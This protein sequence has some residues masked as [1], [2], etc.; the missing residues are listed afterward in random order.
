MNKCRLYFFVVFFFLSYSITCYA[1]NLSQISS[2]EGLSNS[3]IL[4][5]YQDRDGFMWFGSCDGLNMYDGRTIQIYKPTDSKN[6]LSGNLIEQIIGNSD[7]TLWVHTN[8]GL[9]KIDKNKNNIESHSQFDKAYFLCQ[10]LKGEIFVIKK[11]NEI[12]YYDKSTNTFRSIAIKGLIF[13]KILNITVDKNDILWI[14]TK[15]KE[16]KK[17]AIKRERGIELIAVGSF[18]HQNT[19]INCFIDGNSVFFID[20]KKTLY[21]YNLIHKKKQHITNLKKEIELRGEIS[22][23]IKY[24]GDYFVGFK[25]NGLVCLRKAMGSRENYTIEDIG[26]H[27]GVFCLLKDRYQDI[28]WIGTDGKGVFIYSESAYSVKSFRLKD[29]THKVNKPIRALF[30]DKENTLWIGTKGDGILK[31]KN[32]SKLNNIEPDQV[33]HISSSNSSLKDNSV[34]S[35]A[36]SSRNIIWIGS[37]DGIGYYSYKERKIKPLISATD[38]KYIHSICESNDSTLWIASVGMGIFKASIYGDRDNPYLKNIQNIKVNNGAFSSNFFFHIYKENDSIIWFG[39]RGLGAFSYNTDNNKLLPYTPGKTKDEESRI[40][41][42]IFSIY[43]DGDGNLW[44]GTSYGLV[45]NTSKGEKFIFNEV[46][47]FPN[48]TIHGILPDSFTNLW[49]STNQGIISFDRKTNDFH[50]YDRNNGLSVTEFSDGAFYRDPTSGLLL[51]GGI[52]GFVSISQKARQ[53]DI[54]M[55]AIQFNKLLLFGNEKNIMDFIEKGKEKS[56]LKLKY[57]QNFFSIIFTALDYINGNNYSYYYKLKEVSN[58]W[59]NNGKSNVASF[60]NLQPGTYSMLVKYRNRTT[61]MESPEYAITIKIA[62]PWYASTSAYISYGLIL[63]FIIIYIVRY[64]IRKVRQKKEQMLIQIEQKHKENIYESK[65][66][67]FTNIAHEFCTPL[68]LIYGPCNRIINHNGSDSFVIKYTN[69]IQRNAERMNSLILQL[70]EFQRIENGHLQP[71]VERTHITELLS[72]ETEAFIDIAEKSNI[73]FEKDIEDNLNWNIDI[74]FFRIIISNLLSNAFKYSF[75]HG[76]VKIKGFTKEANLC[77]EISNTGKGIKKANLTRIFDR[78]TILDNFENEGQ[79]FSRNGLGLAISYDLIKLLNGTIAVESEIGGWTTFFV[80]IPQGKISDNTIQTENRVAPL[81]NR[82]PT[83]DYIVSVPKYEFD[84]LKPTMLIID[85]E[86]EILWFISE[87]FAPDFNVIPIS[88]MDEIDKTLN[89]ILPN[90]IL[91]DIMM[92]KIDGI[93][94]TK[95]IKKNTRTSHIPLILISAKHRIEEQIEGLSAGA[96]MYITKPFNVDYLK[97]TV[98]QLINRKEI[99]KEYFRSPIS[100]FD[101]TESKLVH[102]EDKK[103]VKN[104]YDIISKNIKSKDLSAKFIAQELNISL[105]HL[106]RKLNEIGEENSPTEMIKDSRLFIAK[107]LLINSKY[108]IDEIIYES[109][110]SARS[111]FFKVFVEKFG[112]SPKEF[113][114]KHIPNL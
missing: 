11:N 29:F 103:F 23:I 2:R 6:K 49:L 24:N 75:R 32:Y 106:Y 112:C 22:S 65:L 100:A 85:D 92:D 114:D 17:Y 59:V 4:S 113:R 55:P 46:N 16:C 66:R 107:D 63:I 70:I 84:K 87:I 18:E 82:N 78:Y 7:N 99:L 108:T 19:L 47:G 8:Y 44:V 28:I 58:Q 79:S 72:K 102:K 31:I 37:E 81:I 86:I 9:D 93:S 96:E 3:S 27:S 53:D 34:Y 30:V 90:I 91:C 110:F 39:N 35:F 15:E 56:I 43:K 97:T 14:F 42:D 33:E 13:D 104:I 67:F 38:M 71:T 95:E 73:Y 105:R 45:K 62:P 41:N 109:G 80:K 94:L 21:E 89:E 26:I 64:S 69:L 10:S 54:Y 88:N 77:I 50:V 74:N 48:N 57:N 61:G 12:H 51:F 68:T 98:N 36:Q 20:D 111:T 83:P 52:N 5:L 60:A 101:L 1:Y 40:I 76:T 25:T